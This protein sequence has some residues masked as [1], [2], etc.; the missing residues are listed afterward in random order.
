MPPVESHTPRMQVKI[1]AEEFREAAQCCRIGA[2]QAAQDAKSQQNP[3][4]VQ[5]F[6]D[7]ARGRRQLAAKF[8]VAALQASRSSGAGPPRG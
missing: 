5:T 3:S 2:F 6:V 7:L 4:V 1:T 8:E